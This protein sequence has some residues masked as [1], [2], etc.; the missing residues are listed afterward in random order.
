MAK[1]ANLLVDGLGLGPGD[2]AAV[3]LPLHW[4]ALV[5]VAGCWQAGLTVDLDTTVGAV[6]FAPEGTAA[7][8]EETVLLSLLPLGAPIRTPAPH[9]TDYAEVLTYA[10]RYVGPSAGASDHALPGVSQAELLSSLPQSVAG[11]VLL[12][13]AQDPLLDR[14]L[15]TAAYLQPVVTGGSAV[16][17]R[18]PD[19]ALLAHRAETERA[20]PAPV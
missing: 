16:L 15:L 12:A 6:L 14:R 3:R 2:V 4:Q 5:V 7:T 20:V 1:T 18:H 8:G 13:P 9:A 19:P 11:R 17:C 10:D